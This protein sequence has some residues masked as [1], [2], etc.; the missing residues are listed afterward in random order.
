MS[1][2]SLFTLSEWLICISS[3]TSFTRMVCRECSSKKLAYG[4]CTPKGCGYSTK[5]KWLFWSQS[6]YP[7]CSQAEGQWSDSGYERFTSVVQT[8]CIRLIMQAGSSAVIWLWLYY[9]ENFLLNLWSINPS[10]MFCRVV[11]VLWLEDEPDEL[12]QF[13][14]VLGKLCC[15]MQ[16]VCK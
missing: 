12:D 10:Q 9:K 11:S 15:L 4:H 16:L 8:N 6:G 7:S 5:T 2:D 1:V 14:Y 3:Y 13:N